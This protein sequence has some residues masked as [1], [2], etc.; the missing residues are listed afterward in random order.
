MYIGKAMTFL[1]LCALIG[2]GLYAFVKGNTKRGA[3]AVRACI[4]MEGIKSG[5]SAEHANQS[6]SMNLLDAPTDIIREAVHIINV[7]YGGKQL[8]LI[9]AAYRSGMISY[10]PTWQR[11]MLRV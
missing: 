10:L 7:E 2:W 4:F 8:P 9:S 5:Y 1:I 11:I 6:A 3:E